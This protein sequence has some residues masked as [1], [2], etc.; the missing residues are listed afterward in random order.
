[1]ANNN[2]R[3]ILLSEDISL[4][5][6]L[7]INRNVVIDGQGRAVTAPLSVKKI[8]IINTEGADGY[9]QG[10]E[11]RNINVA[12]SEAA[13]SDWQSAYAIQIYRSNDVTLNNVTA[14][15]G[16]AGILVN[17]SVVT[18]GGNIGRIRQQ[19]RRHRGL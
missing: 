7:N 4:S 6:T 19:L 1:M 17:G 18:L 8:I 5:E 12:F 16:N 11:L 15:N 3:N 13:P 9:P 14:K 10:A 2:I